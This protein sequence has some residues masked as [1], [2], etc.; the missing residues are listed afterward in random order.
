MLQPSQ[1]ASVCGQTLEFEMKLF[2][3]PV[4]QVV[5][6]HQLPGTEEHRHPYSHDDSLLI[7]LTLSHLSFSPTL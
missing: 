1:R 3:L 2:G 7:L 6:A 4:L 5:T